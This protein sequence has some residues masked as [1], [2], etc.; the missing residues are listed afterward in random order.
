MATRLVSV[1]EFSW[2][3]PIDLRFAI[4]AAVVDKPA[5]SN[6]ATSPNE[7][8][9]WVVELVPIGAL[10]VVRPD[11]STPAAVVVRAYR[12]GRAHSCNGDTGSYRLILL[13]DHVSALG[14]GHGSPNKLSVKIVLK[15]RVLRRG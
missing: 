12:N 13:S 11:V 6:V 2:P 3:T 10:I 14:E 9:I 8:G 7:L 15:L 5:G 4:A 1:G